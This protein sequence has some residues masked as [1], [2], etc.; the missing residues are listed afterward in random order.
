MD[1]VASVHVT[2]IYLSGCAIELYSAIVNLTDPENSNGVCVLTK[3]AP[4]FGNEASPRGLNTPLLSL[5]ES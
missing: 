2:F 5:I 3:V 1:E 4:I